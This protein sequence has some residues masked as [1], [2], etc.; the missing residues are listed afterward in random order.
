MRITVGQQVSLGLNAA[1]AFVAAVLFASRHADIRVDGGSRRDVA[2]VGGGGTARERSPAI[3][4]APASERRHALIERLRR[5]GVANELLA[6]FARADIDV[7]WEKELAQRERD[8]R[9]DERDSLQLGREMAR[10]AALRSALGEEG[11]RQWDRTRLVREAIDDRIEVSAAEADAIYA[12]KQ[13]L[14]Q[15]QFELEKAR[16]KG[17]MDD[18][19]VEDASSKLHSEFNDRMRSLLGQER[20]ATAQGLGDD[21]RAANLR[22]DLGKVEP[23]PDQLHALL[24]AQQDWSARLAELDRKFQDDKG[25]GAY[26]TAL[27]ALDQERDQEY[28]RILGPDVFDALQKHRDPA[29]S[30]MKQ[31]QDLWNL[32]DGAIDYVYGTMKYFAKSVEAYTAQNRA[33]AAN[34]ESVDWGAVDETLQELSSQTRE[35]LRQRL[36]QEAFDHLQRNNVLQLNPGQGAGR[37]SER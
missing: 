7:A 31:Y 9:P 8:A 28:R 21:S 24:K 30:T 35:A 20:F 17:A 34:G 25:P 6:D 36:G 16:T 3:R 4:E 5:L 33:R 19:T 10:I 2:A 32:D 27:K 13:D 29:Y 22:E 18:A 23:G 14:R 1:L 26:P 37:P 15:R 11:F 12:L